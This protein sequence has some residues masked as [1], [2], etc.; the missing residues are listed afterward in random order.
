MRYY[1]IILISIAFTCSAFAEEC[2]YPKLNVSHLKEVDT[3]KNVCVDDQYSCLMRAFAISHSA[4]GTDEN[5]NV[6]NSDLKELS[7]IE[8]DFEITNRLCQYK[9]AMKSTQGTC[10]IQISKIGW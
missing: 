8:L 3:T 10:Y 1:Q 9:A 2:V 7:N 6:S 5:Y 4:T